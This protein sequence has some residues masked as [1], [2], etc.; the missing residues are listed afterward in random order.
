MISGGQVL[1]EQEAEP[2]RPAP[3][4]LS[5]PVGKQGQFPGS[6]SVVTPLFQLPQQSSDVWVNRVG[7]SRI[8]RG[9]HA[10]FLHIVAEVVLRRV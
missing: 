5:R 7:E 3:F 10:P 6:P 1:R 9:R 4:T 2:P 8:G